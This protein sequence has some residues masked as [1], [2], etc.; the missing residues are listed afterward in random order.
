MWHVD[1]ILEAGSVKG[2]KSIADRSCND[3][4]SDLFSICVDFFLSESI[5]WRLKLKDSIWRS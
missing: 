5:A 4:M 1:W 2:V 3:L